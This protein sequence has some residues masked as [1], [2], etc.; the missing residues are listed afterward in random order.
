[1]TFGENMKT[2][3]IIA[4]ISIV[5]LSIPSY[6]ANI[7]GPVTVVSNLC[8]DMSRKADLMYRGA[9]K[10]I[11]P[12]YFD[13]YSLPPDQCTS[14][15]YAFSSFSFISSTNSDA[16]V[17]KCINAENY[18]AVD[19]TFHTVE[20]NGQWYIYPKSHEAKAA[21]FLGPAHISIT[22][23]VSAKKGVPIDIVPDWNEM[24]KD[25]IV[26]HQSSFVPK[27]IGN[28]IPILL[29]SGTRYMGTIDA[30]RDNEAEFTLPVG[31]MT[32]PRTSMAEQSRVMLW[33]DDF[34]RSAAKQEVLKAQAAFRS[35]VSDDKKRYIESVSQATAQ[36][37]KDST[38]LV[39]VDWNW[40]REHGY[41]IAEGMVR[42]VTQQPMRNIC[43]A[44][45]FL[46]SSGEFV[47]S[48]DSLVSYNPI[49]PN[50]TSPFR[51][52]ARGN[53]EIRKARIGF[54]ELFGGSVDHVTEERYKE[55][56][57]GGK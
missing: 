19:L 18:W 46:T 25:A 35:K 55:L 8:V 28:R 31:K 2:L 37:Y 27:A 53:P 40:R 44:V 29:S 36:Y 54:K 41:V 38:K 49:L 57:S 12:S 16:I 42:N 48:E 15:A 30:I 56:I 11:A 45:T 5:A 23:W 52:M 7:I 3:S 33:A 26:K 1:V 20:E 47:T 34:A 43:A 17:V 32:I 22:P 10:Y 4:I 9:I 6:A 21:S 13:K 24:Y 51:V 39:L 50:Q 14:D